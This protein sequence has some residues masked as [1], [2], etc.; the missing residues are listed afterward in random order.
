MA[1][2]G[3]LPYLSQLR[4]C[5]LGDLDPLPCPALGDGLPELVDVEVAWRESKRGSG[6]REGAG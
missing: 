4:E 6:R 3:P 1:K 2:T 5:A